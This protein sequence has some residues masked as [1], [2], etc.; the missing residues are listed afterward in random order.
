MMAVLGLPNEAQRRIA[1]GSLPGR[2][3]TVVVKD[4]DGA[5]VGRVHPG[6][7][8]ARGG[9]VTATGDVN[10]DLDEEVIAATP[11]RAGSPASVS[12]YDGD[13][14]KLVD[15]FR[16]IPESPRAGLSIATG[17]ID[18]RRTRRDH[19]RTGRPR[20]EPGADLPP[21]RRRLPHAQGL[22]RT[23][24]GVGPRPGRRA[25]IARVQLADAPAVGHAASGPEA[26]LG[27]RPPG[28]H[29]AR[30][31]GPGRPRR[32]GRSQHTDLRL[33]QRRGRGLARGA[34][35]HGEGGATSRRPR[36]PR[37]HDGKQ[38][39]RDRVAVPAARAGYRGGFRR[40]I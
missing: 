18:R 28:G 40:P 39:H 14:L 34:P 29:P 3:N 4:G 5:S 16:P 2:P 32:L 22:R 8:N 6:P 19:R 15:R 36:E 35:Q 7:R 10:G 31:A 26:R 12:V 11:A 1:L 27:R 37:R 21:Q 24:A 9:V 13:T 30:Q 20:G 33:D 17:D 25:R 38:G 23:G